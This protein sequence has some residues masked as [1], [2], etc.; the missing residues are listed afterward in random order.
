ME[1]VTTSSSMPS[2]T[3]SF[4]MEVFMEVPTNLTAGFYQ[5]GDM[6]ILQ[7][8]GSENLVD[9]QEYFNILLLMHNSTKTVC[10]IISFLLPVI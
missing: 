10:K 4:F 8:Y 6:F 5:A 9:F 2:L 1:G 7:A 3:A